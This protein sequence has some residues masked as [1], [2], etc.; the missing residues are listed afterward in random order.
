VVAIRNAGASDLGALVELDA[1]AQREGARRESLR[2]A[3][4][5][6]ECF[7]ALRAE[8]VTGYAVLEHSFYGNGFLA[9]V[10]VRASERRSGIGPALVREA[11]VRCRSA[12][13][14]TPTNASNAPMQRLLG[15]QRARSGGWRLIFHQGTPAGANP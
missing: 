3:I 6:G 13:L 2:E 11:G 12:K 15:W 5:W 14:F 4:A 10:A 9:L 8:K 1:T 7:V